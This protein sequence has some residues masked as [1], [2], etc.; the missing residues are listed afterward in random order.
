VKNYA[1]PL[2]HLIAMKR[3]QYKASGVPDPLAPDW[4]RALLARLA[5]TDYETCS[6]V[7]S[8]LY[9]GDTWVASH[10]GLRSSHILHDWFPVYNPELREFGPGR[11]LLKSMCEAAT[12]EGIRCIDRGA[13]ESPAKRDI[14]N[15]RH[16]Y[17]RGA[18]FQSGTKATAVRMLWSLKWLLAPSAKPARSI[19][20]P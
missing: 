3:R 10:F 2:S 5:G 20:A 15:E 6:G 12:N 16:L 8:T 4:A 7:L 17:Y 1:A 19:P 11:L 9:A 14:G 13:G 18:W